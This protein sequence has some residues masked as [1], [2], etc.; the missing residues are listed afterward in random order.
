MDINT[1]NTD[2]ELRIKKRR[3]HYNKILQKCYNKIN[4]TSKKKNFCF[5]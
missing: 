3:E 1:L 4:Y 2:R 5:F